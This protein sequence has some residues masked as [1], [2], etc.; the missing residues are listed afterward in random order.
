MPSEVQILLP[1]PGAQRRLESDSSNLE[2]AGE[3]LAILLPE[4][5]VQA[6]LAQLAERRHG[7]AEVS[8]SIPEG[9]SKRRSANA[10]KG[11][12]KD[13]G[14]AWVTKRRRRFV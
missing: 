1:A 5:K 4:P 13:R 2:Q 10:S 11:S 14:I 8:G 12:S 7:K 3:S 6:P 9:G